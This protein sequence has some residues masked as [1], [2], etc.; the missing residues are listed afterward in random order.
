MPRPGA[1]SVGHTRCCLM[2]QSSLKSPPSQ[3]EDFDRGR[4]SDCKFCYI[5]VASLARKLLALCSAFARVQT[6]E[7]RLKTVGERLMRGGWREGGPGGSAPTQIKDRCNRQGRRL[8]KETGTSVSCDLNPPTPKSF[9]PLQ[10][11]RT[12]IGVTGIHRPELSKGQGRSAAKQRLPRRA[13]RADQI[14]R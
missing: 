1:T 14:L 4:W 10:V 11:C 13:S 9:R 8:G 6:S 7:G 2:Q 12:V 5:S 3:K